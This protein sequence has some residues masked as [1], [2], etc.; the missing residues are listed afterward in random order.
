M[1]IKQDGF[2]FNTIGSGLVHYDDDT[3]NTA[4]FIATANWNGYFLV[5]GCTVLPTVQLGVAYLPNTEFGTN[6]SFG[7]CRFT[8][9]DELGSYIANATVGIGFR[10]DNV[11]LELFASQQNGNDLSSRT[12]NAR[13]DYAF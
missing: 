4:V 6:F 13:I 8:A 12:F 11:F 9:Q 3:L 7:G 1:G 10:K 5:D 2:D